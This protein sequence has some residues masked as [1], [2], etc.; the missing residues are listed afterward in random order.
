[1]NWLNIETKTLDAE[2]FI[3]S[4]PTDRGTWLCLQRFSVG[5]EN[6]GR[7][8]GCKSWPDRKWQQLVRI[9]K[10]EAMRGSLLWDWQGEDLV[11]WEYP[12]DKELEVKQKR[13]TAKTNGAKGGRPKKTED[14]TQQEPTS[15]NSDKAERNGKE[16]NG[17]EGNSEFSPSEEIL[18]KGC[19]K[20]TA[21]ERGRVKVNR[22]T[23]LMEKVGTWFKQKPSTLWTVAEFMALRD[24]NPTDEDVALIGEHYSYSLD[25]N[26][27]RFTT[28]A[29]LLNQWPAARAKANAFFDENQQLPRP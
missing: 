29:T 27:Y 8:I 5:Q 2:N 15:V 3:G 1:M 28:I 21:T 16:E 13:D 9:T 6:G 26:G 11:V 7:I 19:S 4:E 22:N 12:V 17:K 24:V 23:P 25:R 20:L 10:K 18:P 14:E